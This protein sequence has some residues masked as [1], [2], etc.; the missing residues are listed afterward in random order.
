MV[1]RS[2][3]WM[4]GKATCTQCSIWKK[5]TV[6]Y[7]HVPTNTSTTLETPGRTRWRGGDRALGEE[8]GEEAQGVAVVPWQ[9][10]RS[11]KRARRDGRIH[12]WKGR[13]WIAVKRGGETRE[14][15]GVYGVGLAVWESGWQ[16]GS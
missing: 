5:Y 16:S 8:R 12:G 7:L 2:P 13:G 4:V 1:E 9:R 6:F 15:G 11:L 14:T 10:T 3:S